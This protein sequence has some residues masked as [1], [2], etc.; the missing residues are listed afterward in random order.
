MSVLAQGNPRAIYALL[1][2][3]V[4]A[5]LVEFGENSRWQGGEIAVTLVTLGQNM[6]V[7]VATAIPA[8]ATQRS[9]K[10]NSAAPRGARPSSSPSSDGEMAQ[11]QNMDRTNAPIGSMMLDVRW[12]IKSN[13]VADAK[14]GHA[15]SGCQPDKTLNESTVA[16]PAAKQAP[17]SATLAANLR[18]P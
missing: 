6:G 18:H 3:S 8:G 15:P 12:S 11:P 1:F 9:R 4:S 10:R 5:T 13:H 17:E 2:T 16:R 7:S 14:A